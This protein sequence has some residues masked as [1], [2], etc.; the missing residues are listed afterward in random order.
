MQGKRQLEMPEVTGM[1]KISICAGWAGHLGRFARLSD[2][3][4]TVFQP[5]ILLSGIKK[6]S[7]ESLGKKQ[8]RFPAK[9]LQ[10]FLYMHEQRVNIWADIEL[11][12]P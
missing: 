9:F 1:T 12:Q 2:T 6:R 7:W 8:N 10:Q 4:H 11:A 5:Y 3:G